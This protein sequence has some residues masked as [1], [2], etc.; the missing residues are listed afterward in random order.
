MSQEQEKTLS[1]VTLNAVSGTPLDDHSVRANVVAAAHALAERNGVRIHHVATSDV[2]VVVI[3]G[4][5]RTAAM[6]FA[7]ELRTITNTWYEHKF[8]DGPLWGTRPPSHEA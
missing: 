8:R 6:G 1:T 2:G 7:T 5:D 4:A 3:L